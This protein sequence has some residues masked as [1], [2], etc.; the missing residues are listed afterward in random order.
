M[1]ERQG[2]DEAELKQLRHR[3]VDVHARVRRH[4]RLPLASY[5]LKAV[6]GWQGF[7]WSQAGADG[8]RALLWWRQWQGDGPDRR[9][10]RHGLRW[11]FDYNRD[12]CLATWAV[13]AWLLQQDQTSGS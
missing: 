13:A 12:D 9:G 7:R 8:A 5:G 2:V 4:W 3:L 10:N 6:A 11:I 1:A